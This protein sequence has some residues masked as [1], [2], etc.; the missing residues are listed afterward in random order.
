MI[1]ISIAFSFPLFVFARKIFVK[2]GAGNVT[3]LAVSYARIMFA[4]TVIIFF[5]NIATAILRAEGDTKRVMYAMVFGAILNIFLDPIFIY[6]LDFGV[7]GAAWAT[8]ISIS[9]TSLIL[10]RW[11]FLNKSTFVSFKFKGFSFDKNIT[12]D[13]MKVGIPAAVTQLSMSISMLIINIII[14]HVGG[15]DGV[16]VYTTGWRVSMIAILPLIGISTGVM[17][18]TGA[19][20]GSKDYKKLET[21]FLYAI[22]FGLL[23]EIAIALITVIFAPWI[24]LVFTQGKDSY[25]IKDALITFL[26]IMGFFYPTVALGMFSSSMFQGTG[27]GVNSLIVTILRT[28]ALTVPFVLLLAFFFNSGLK[29]VWAGIVL[30]NF[31]GSIVAFTWAKLFINKLKSMDKNDRE[32]IK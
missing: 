30:S 32:A 17:S 5:T 14:V 15:T 23:I 13:I 1:I 7:M 29:G 28:I 16:A 2:I 27:K 21:A 22:K 19:A 6:K 10:F 24:T 26:K 3:D 20:Y 31:I 25:R 4:G 11:L 9:L 12:K 18:I 8:M